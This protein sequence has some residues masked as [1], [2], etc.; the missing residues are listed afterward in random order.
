MILTVEEL[1]SQVDCGDMTDEVIKSR[2]TAI[3]GVI[4]AYTHNNFQNRNIRFV[5]ESTNG[6][7][8]QNKTDFL[9]EGDT[10]QITA[11][12]VNDG[13]YTVVAITD[14]YI[15]VDRE[16]Y[17]VPNNKVTKIEYPPDVVQC[18]IDLFEWKHKFGS[19]VG[20][21]S[22]SETLSRHS[23]SVTYEDS[24]T[25]FMGYPRGILN[26]LSLQMKARF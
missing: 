14:E 11:S 6:D 23:E 7:Q 12:L 26:G 15:T 3:E 8:I 24:A 18:A 21:K 1:K 9:K 19:K 4:R 22:E 17:G 2:L 16:I 20:I 5:A 10:I 25:L 13:L